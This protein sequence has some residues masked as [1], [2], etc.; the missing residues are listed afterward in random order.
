MVFD[1]P[2][3]GRF[4]FVVLGH[5]GALLV[6]LAGLVWCLMHEG[7][8]ATAVFCVLI[9]VLLLA[10]LL[11]HLAQTNRELN[12]FINAVRYDDFSQAFNDTD[13]DAGFG[14]LREA[15]AGA[16]QSIETS[17]IN[18][19]A[20]LRELKAVVEH[21]PVPL[22]SVFPD[23]RLKLWNNAS[24]RLFGDGGRTIPSRTEQLQ[25]YSEELFKHCL[26]IKPGQ[27]I[28]IHF[29]QRGQTRRMTLS[30]SQIV[31]AGNAELLLSVQDIQSEL[32][33][34]QLQAWQELV[35]VLTHEIMNSITPISSLSKTAGSIMAQLPKD[36][37]LDADTV[38]EDLDD[39]DSALSTVS[40]RCDNLMRFV[41]SY[42]E[43]TRLPL[44]NRAL[45]PIAPMLAHVQALL[46][47][48]GEI[49]LDIE[50]SPTTLD[51]SLDRDMIEQVLINLVTNA[52]HALQGRD[53]GAIGIVAR[54]STSGEVCIDVDDNGPGISDEV[55]AKMFVPFYTTKT[56]GSGVGLALARQVMIAHGGSI[57]YTRLAGGGSRFSLHF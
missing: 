37:P 21:V 34:N 22:L 33:A 46:G 51:A 31:V 13:A 11:R 1:R 39:I 30:A 40:K 32:D 2:L 50:C 48:Q 55:Q 36:G 52:R 20:S 23:G 53:G 16:L 14:E 12:R 42:R 7:F 29:D 45:T 26:S 56:E 3:L 47:E 28:L 49:S 54:L 25:D 18:Q 44:P 15:L 17:R 57:Q 19:E 5:V 41:S 35:R 43:L 8:Q 6:A 4:T 38:R 9:A 27:R 24:R 10:S